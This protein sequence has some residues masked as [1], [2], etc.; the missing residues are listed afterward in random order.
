[1][2]LMPLTCLKQI[3]K[4]R[5]I[6]FRF[7]TNY[8]HLHTILSNRVAF[9]VHTRFKYAANNNKTRRIRCDI[10]CDISIRCSVNQLERKQLII[11]IW[12]LGRLTRHDMK[13][14]IHC[15]RI[16]LLNPCIR[17]IDDRK[18]ILLLFSSRS[19]TITISII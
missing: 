10:V 15:W 19:Q 9:C 6:T 11:V 2:L 4:K 14:F 17:S 7:L 12:N 13:L 1:M 8:S 18:K 5:F 16:L 3:N